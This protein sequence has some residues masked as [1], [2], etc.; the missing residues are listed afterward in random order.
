MNSWIKTFV[1][2]MSYLNVKF[3]SGWGLLFCFLLLSCMWLFIFRDN[4]S[5]RNTDKFIRWQCHHCVLFVWHLL[6][7]VQSHVINLIRIN[8]FDICNKHD[9]C[10]CS[11]LSQFELLVWTHWCVCVCACVRLCLCVSVSVFVKAVIHLRAKSR[12]YNMMTLNWF[13]VTASLNE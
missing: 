6:H 5:F 2:N 10:F 8:T 3:F 11:V 9:C 4:S 1:L 13:E 12:D 7:L